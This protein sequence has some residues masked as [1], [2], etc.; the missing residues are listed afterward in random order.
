MR[1]QFDADLKSLQEMI[2]ELAMKTKK[3]V[4]KSMSYS[5]KVLQESSIISASN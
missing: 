5:I 2:I 3:A 1:P 4:M